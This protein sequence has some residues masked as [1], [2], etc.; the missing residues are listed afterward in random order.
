MP[1]TAM[2]MQVMTEM[3]GLLQSIAQF[4]NST[5]FV[6]D[7]EDIAD[8]LKNASFPCVGLIYNGMRRNPESGRAV[9]KGLSCEL[10][11]TVMLI[12]KGQTI[13]V[14]DQKPLAIGLL[15]SLRLAILG[16]RSVTGHFYCFEME[17]PGRPS[18][19]LIF[20]GQRWSVPVQLTPT[21]GNL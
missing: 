13:V 7:D 9:P 8:K 1:N 5:V 4:Q 3:Q 20:W 21:V 14:T 18:K 19:G 15:D 6:Y 11:F 2:A 10:M 16:R 17:A 12:T